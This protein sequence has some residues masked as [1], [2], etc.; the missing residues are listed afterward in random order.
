MIEDNEIATNKLIHGV[1]AAVFNFGIR[2]EYT[3]RNPARAVGSIEGKPNKHMDDWTL[4]EFKTFISS[5]G[6]FIYYVL[7]MTLYY[8]GLRKGE[9]LALTWGDVDF[10][11]NTLNVDKTKTKKGVTT[12]KT[13]ATRQIQMPKFVMRLLSQLKAQAEAKPKMTY[14]VFGEFH[15]ALSESTLDRKF[16]KWM[17]DAGVKKIRIHDMRH[18]HASYL[19]N[20]GTVISVISK[21]L[22]H[23]H[24]STTLDTY[25]HLYPSTEKDAVDDMEDDFKQADILQLIK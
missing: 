23:A 16:Q 5:A 8:S 14:V 15:K 22:G 2:E 25:S 18:S 1:L 21:R 20:K 9:A 12:T 11:N 17:K 6:E 24:V 7:F 10:E 13:G 3:T 4:D 19:I